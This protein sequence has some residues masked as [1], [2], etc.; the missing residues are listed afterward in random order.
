ML[1]GISGSND[2]L[3]SNS[4]VSELLSGAVPAVQPDGSS[5]AA[6]SDVDPDTKLHRRAAS[7]LHSL[8]GALGIVSGR[9]P[10]MG[11]PRQ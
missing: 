4:D 6:S 10:G 5:P 8:S 2:L 7:A 9:R 11:P 1:A 3:T